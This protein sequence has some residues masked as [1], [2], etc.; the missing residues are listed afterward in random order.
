MGRDIDFEEYGIENDKSNG[1]LLIQQWVAKVQ[2]GEVKFDSLV[3]THLLSINL[4]IQ[5]F[6][7]D[8]LHIH[9]L[10]IYYDNVDLVKRMSYFGVSSMKD[11]KCYYIVVL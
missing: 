1:K 11:T 8:I 10:N 3:G 6:F 4:S 2:P 5:R 7:Y 9:L